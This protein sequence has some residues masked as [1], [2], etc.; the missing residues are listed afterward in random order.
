[1]DFSDTKE[2]AAFRT[3]AREWIAANAPTY[4][5]ET[6][7]TSGFGSTRTGEYDPL[8]EAKKWQKKKADAGWAC[9]QWPKEYGGRAATP[10]QSVI[11]NQEE[12]VYSRLSG[13]FII[14]QGMCAP[15]MMAYASEEHKQ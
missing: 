11:W 14:G 2:E 6:L 12:G 8:T 1:M 5:F 15:T 9:I 3:E 7:S 13:T 4:L 10:I